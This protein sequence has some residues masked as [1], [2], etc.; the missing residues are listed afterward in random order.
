MECALWSR[1]GYGDAAEWVHLGPS[2]L[3]PSHGH[4]GDSQ[5]GRVSSLEQCNSISLLKANWPHSCGFQRTTCQ[6]TCVG[7]I[8]DCH[9][10]LGG[11]SW[12]ICTFMLPTFS[13]LV[14]CGTIL[15]KKTVL[16]QQTVPL[17]SADNWQQIAFLT[18]FKH[19]THLLIS[20]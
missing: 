7:G 17:R 15:H 4:L 13:P 3:P 20:K 8:S 19:G 1:S 12:H 11:C 6:L 14:T 10:D 16:P 18:C 9:N 5:R 2:F